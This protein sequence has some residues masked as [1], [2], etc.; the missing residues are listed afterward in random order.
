MFDLKVD[1]FP[2]Q[3]AILYTTSRRPMEHPCAVVFHLS[4]LKIWRLLNPLVFLIRPYPSGL[5]QLGGPESRSCGTERGEMGN[6][7]T[8]EW[9][10]ATHLPPIDL[11]W[12]MR[13]SVVMECIKPPSIDI[14]R[15]SPLPFALESFLLIWLECIQY[16]SYLRS[17]H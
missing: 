8:L 9:N 11:K 10:K 5:P 14:S 17:C 1:Y 7:T 15:L 6:G 3:Y 13:N 16:R 2:H 4:L 12:E